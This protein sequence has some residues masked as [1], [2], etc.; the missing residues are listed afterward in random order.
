MIQKGRLKEAAD[1]IRRMCKVNRKKV[2]D[3]LD[4]IIA[5]IR[6]ILYCYHYVDS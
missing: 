1:V 6:V 5:E 3:D 2:P 4:Q